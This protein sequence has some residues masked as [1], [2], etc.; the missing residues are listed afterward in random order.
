MILCILV[1]LMM[2]R[3]V[4]HKWE[5]FV[6]NACGSITCDLQRIGQSA[7]NMVCLIPFA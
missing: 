3:L 1:T 4:L 5:K 7:S 6:N 2:Y